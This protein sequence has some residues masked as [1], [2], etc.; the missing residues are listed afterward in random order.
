MVV[1]MLLFEHVSQPQVLAHLSS[2][3]M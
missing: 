1:G 2:L 3:M